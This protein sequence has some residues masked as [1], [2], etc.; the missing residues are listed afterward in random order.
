MDEPPP[1]LPVHSNMPAC[2]IRK[3]QCLVWNLLRIF[4]PTLHRQRQQRPYD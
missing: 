3:C 2:Q 1:H 4:C